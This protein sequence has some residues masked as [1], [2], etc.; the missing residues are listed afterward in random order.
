[1][2]VLCLDIEQMLNFFWWGGKFN[3]GRGGTLFMYSKECFKKLHEFN[4]AL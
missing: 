2:S 4:L 1:M 3:G